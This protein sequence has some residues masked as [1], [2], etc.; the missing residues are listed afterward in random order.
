MPIF[1]VFAESLALHYKVKSDEERLLDKL[2]K[3]YNPSARPVL[4]SSHTVTV[5]LKFSLLQIQDLVSTAL[6]QFIWPKI[7]PFPFLLLLSAID[8]M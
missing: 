4:N 6:F 3:D 2:F 5:D 1:Y 7:N 8:L